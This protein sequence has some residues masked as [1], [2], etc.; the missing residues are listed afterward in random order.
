[1]CMGKEKLDKY[2]PSVTGV[3]NILL[4]KCDDENKH[5]L[6]YYDDID[7]T[8]INVADQNQVL[9]EGSNLNFATYKNMLFNGQ[10]FSYHAN[11]KHL[12]NDISK[13]A[14]G[15]DTDTIEKGGNIASWVEEKDN[16]GLKWDVDYVGT[17][18][19]PKVKPAGNP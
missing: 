14:M 12:L 7:H 18:E 17:S 15:V 8:I 3:Y 13:R 4:M 5:Q 2:Y 6:W 9:L 19:P 16:A 10:R 11:T 1:M